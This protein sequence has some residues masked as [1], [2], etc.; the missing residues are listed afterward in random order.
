MGEAELTTE[1]AAG[2][3]GVGVRQVQ[4]WCQQGRL[5]YRRAGPVYL[6]AAA[7]VRRFRRRKPGPKRRP[8]PPNPEQEA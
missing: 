8:R 3:L 2:R 4:R 5:I 1:E 7:S 6:I